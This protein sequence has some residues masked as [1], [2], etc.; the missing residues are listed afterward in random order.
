MLL[1]NDVSIFLIWLGIILETV[2]KAVNESLGSHNKIYE[3]VLPARNMAGMVFGIE[4]KASLQ[5]QMW[6]STLS[7]PFRQVCETTRIVSNGEPVLWFIGSLSLSWL[8][9]ISKRQ[10]WFPFIYFRRH[11]TDC[12]RSFVLWRKK[13]KNCPSP[14]PFFYICIWFCVTLHTNCWFHFNH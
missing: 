5:S 3:R 6:K 11:F 12:H 8:A 9:R 7:N 4:G 14:P 13:K 1:N 2:L 10:T